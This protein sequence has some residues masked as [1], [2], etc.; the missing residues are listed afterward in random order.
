MV[1]EVD[2]ALAHAELE[3]VRSLGYA[4][5]V[6]VGAAA[7]FERIVHVPSDTAAPDL[8]GVLPLL[9]ERAASAGPAALDDPAGVTSLHA[10]V[11]DS[12][13]Q[14]AVTL[15]LNGFPGN[16]PVSRLEEC[17]DSLV[18][19]AQSITDAIGGIHPV[20]VS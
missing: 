1:G 17:R 15:T 10:P 5:S 7:E 3:Q 19:A 18:A 2:A 8:S 14:V 4:V 9:I 12:E 6:D 13:G 20:Q 16:D 11:F